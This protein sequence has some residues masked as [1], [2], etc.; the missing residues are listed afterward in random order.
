M[1]GIS[2]YS[3][4]GSLKLFEINFEIQELLFISLTNNKEFC[5]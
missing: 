2:F 5:N 4:T 1:F 3:S